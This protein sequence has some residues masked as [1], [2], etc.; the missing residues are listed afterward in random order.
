MVAFQFPMDT[1]KFI[2]RI[3]KEQMYQLSADHCLMFRVEFANLVPLNDIEHPISASKC[4][5]KDGRPL[6]RYRPKNDY[7]AEHPEMALDNGRIITANWLEIT[8]TEQDFRT[9]EL[10][11]DWESCV[12]KDCVAYKKGYL[13][14]AFVKAILKLYKDKT[15]LKGIDGEEVNYMA[16]KEMLNSA[17]GMCVT[18]IVRE[19]LMYDD[20]VLS[21]CYSNYED[22]SDK[23]YEEYLEHQIDR[24]NSNPY[25]FLFYAWGVWVTAYAR[26]NLFSGI[27][28]AGYD[29]IY[30]DTDSIKITNPE[31]HMDYI[32]RYNAD[33]EEKLKKA[34]EYHRIDFSEVKP[35]NI[36]GVEKLLGA[37]EFEGIYDE[38]KTLGAK[39]YLTRIDNKWSLTAAGVNKKTGMDYLLLQSEKIG[40]S[41]FDLFSLDLVI[42]KEYSGRK[43]LTYIDTEM[44]GEITDY[45]GIQY[46][47]KE[48]TAIHMEASEYSFNPVDEFIKYL[49]S[50]R[51]ERW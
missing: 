9:Y 3:T 19:N 6:L 42:P 10:F 46:N 29:Y 2:G 21:G 38:F 23:Q 15:I 1:G 7:K 13:P 31:K 22:M 47:Y 44:D 20:E 12:I 26:A 39:R 34:C 14:T 36:H 35:S 41:P 28:A 43:I 25:R 11:Y 50:I 8:C 45:L 40:V 49:F 16:S 32:N 17:Y 30:S 27:R 51:E 4:R 5:W 18:D 24:Y 33:I 37:W 48:L